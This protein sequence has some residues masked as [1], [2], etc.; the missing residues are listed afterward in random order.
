M[1][2]TTN[3]IFAFPFAPIAK[4]EKKKT[5]IAFQQL[6]QTGKTNIKGSLMLVT[7]EK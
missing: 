7:R 6:C 1:K 3:L 4:E 2:T 5:M